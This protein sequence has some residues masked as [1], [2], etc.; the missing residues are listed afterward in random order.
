MKYLVLGVL[1]YR[2]IGVILMVFLL[3]SCYTSR[4]VNYLQSDR[5]RMAMELHRTPYLVQPHDILD[6]KV[7]SR[8]QE[9]N[10]LFNTTSNDNVRLQANPASNFLTGYPIDPE[11]KVKIAIV[12]EL[13]VSN[14]TVEEIRDLVQSEI[15]KYLV[16][17]LVSVKLVSFKVSVLGDVKSPGTNYVFNTQSNI[18]EALS[19]A[20]DLNLSA[21]RKDVKLIRQ[22]GDESIVINLDLR[23]PSIITSPYYFLHPNDVIYVEPSKQNLVRNNLGIFTVLLSAI[24]TGILVFDFVQN[25]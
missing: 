17:A 3:S 15:D 18:F 13:K 4:R 20:G 7:K 24:S 21:R 2:S 22:K 11:G 10:A 5:Q 9:Q 23:D 12:G 25:N 19:A 16:D 14:M 1:K 8:D 6:I